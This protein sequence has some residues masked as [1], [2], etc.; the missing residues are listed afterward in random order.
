MIGPVRVTIRPRRPLLSV[1]TDQPARRTARPAPS[2]GRAGADATAIADLAAYRELRLIDSALDACTNVF[3]EP[4]PAF[5]RRLVRDLIQ[6]PCEE[7]WDAAHGVS[8]S[9]EVTLWQALL[10]HTEYDVTAGPRQVV[11][12]GGEGPTICRTPWAAVPTASQ[13]RRA[14]LTHA[15]LMTVDG[16]VAGDRRG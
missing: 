14:I 7:L 8:L 9:R 15:Y 4:V 16:A 1:S 5:A 10:A 12:E 11:T 6:H 13:V 3:G 2:S